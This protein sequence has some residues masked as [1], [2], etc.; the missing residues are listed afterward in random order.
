MSLTAEHVVK[1]CKLGQGKETC[2]FLFT[3]PRG[4]EC[5]KGTVMEAM[6]R[7]RRQAKTMNAPGDNC[8]GKKG[9]VSPPKAFDLKESIEA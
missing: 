4:F 8:E 6:I 7:G 1:V 3:S 2:S 9:G 5:A